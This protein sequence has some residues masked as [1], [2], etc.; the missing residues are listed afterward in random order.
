MF[1]F[2]VAVIIGLAT[3]VAGLASYWLVS[4]FPE[5]ASFLDETE[6]KFVVARL[7]T[8]QKHSAAGEGLN[9]RPII[10]C[11]LDWKTW[12]GSIAYMGCDGAL[13]SFS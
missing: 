1:N 13:Y 2:L 4:D 10:Q 6:K 7:Q 11:F 12:V 5:T 9:W 3:F 8:D